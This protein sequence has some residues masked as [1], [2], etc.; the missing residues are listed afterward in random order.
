MNK[1]FFENNL[2]YFE[3]LIDFMCLGKEAMEFKGFRAENG[4]EILSG[5]S[6]EC[7]RVAELIPRSGRKTFALQSHQWTVLSQK[8]FQNQKLNSSPGCVPTLRFRL[9]T[10]FS[11]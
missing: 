10:I 5:K 1:G 4:E 6:R 3:H 2:M 9:I 11:C 7:W 8:L